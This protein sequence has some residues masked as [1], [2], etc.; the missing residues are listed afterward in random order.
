VIPDAARAE[1]MIRLV[2]DPDPLR[3][4]FTAAAAGVERIV[5]GEVLAIPALRLESIPGYPTTIVAF[6]SDVPEL[7][8]AW[9]KPFMFGP[10][11]IHVAHTDRER[12]SKQE[13]LD[14]VLA[15]GNIVRHL[16][17]QHAATA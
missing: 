4:A 5:L 7:S 6:A 9:G 8:P 2:G 1:V 17:S 14:A 16:I 12:I 10:G 13:L 11:S 3:R 15:Y